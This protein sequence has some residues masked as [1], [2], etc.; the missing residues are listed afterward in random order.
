MVINRVGITNKGHL[1]LEHTLVNLTLGMW[2]KT[3]KMRLIMG[4][5]WW[6]SVPDQENSHIKRQFCIISYRHTL[7]WIKILDLGVFWRASEKSTKIK[8]GIITDSILL[9]CLIFAQGL[10]KKV[11]IT[12]PHHHQQPNVVD[13]VRETN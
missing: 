13:V 1:R 10:R 3:E 11:A 4:M 6:K 5:R 12:P 7:V 9:Q 8:K 2:R